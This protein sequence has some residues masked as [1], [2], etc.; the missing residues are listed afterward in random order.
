MQNTEEFS[1]FY[2]QIFRKMF[3]EKRRQISFLIYFET[4]LLEIIFLHFKDLYHL[5]KIMYTLSVTDFKTQI[6]FNTGNTQD[7]RLK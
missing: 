5:W 3:C 2:L 6:R 1:V 7:K 4:N